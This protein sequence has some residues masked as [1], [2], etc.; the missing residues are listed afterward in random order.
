MA[1]LVSVIVPTYNR[2]YCLNRALNSVLSQEGGIKFELIVV[3]DGSTDETPKLLEPLAKEGRIEVLTQ[4]NRGVAAARNLGL[5]VAKGE[6][7]AFLDSDDEWSQGKLAAQ[8]QDLKDRPGFLISQCQE[9]WIRGDKRVNPGLKHQKLQGSIFNEATRLCLISPSAVILK[10]DLLKEVGGF[11]ESFLA[12]EDYD[13]W[14]RLSARYEIGLLD[15]ALVTRYG[16]RA[17]QL[18]AQPGLD[19]YRVLALKKILNSGLLDPEKKLVAAA[20]L[21]KRARIYAAGRLKRG[22]SPDFLEDF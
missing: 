4:A 1:P 14:L 9:I 5:S 10:T 11:D 3:D 6:W 16:G 19:Y 21:K 12:C 22:L 15:K 20:E 8:V 18:S 13:L 7:V 2:A 17:D